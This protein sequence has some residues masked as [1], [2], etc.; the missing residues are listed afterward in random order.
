[1]QR[2]GGIL[3]TVQNTRNTSADDLLKVARQRVDGFVRRGVTTVEIKSGYGLNVEAEYKMLDVARQCNSDKARI[4]TTFLGAHTL[5]ADLKND[6]KKYVNQVITEQLPKCAPIADHIDIF[7]DK[8]AFTLDEA[9]AILSAGQKMG[10]KVKAHAEQIEHSGCAKLVADMKGISADHLE[11][12]DEAG[13]EAM[14][15]AGVVAVMLPGAQFY[16]KDISPPTALL[17][18]YNVKMA[19]GTDL[20]PGSSPVHDILQMATMSTILQGLTVEEAVLG[21][22]KH[23]GLA[24]GMDNVG[25]L[26]PGSVQDL[27]LYRPAPGEPANVESLIQHMGAN[28]C[29]LTVKDGK[30]VWDSYY[31]KIN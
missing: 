27:C 3:S 19:V 24:L 29:M 14:G 12:L 6:R 1:M 13:A 11:R 17:R 28:E 23:A 18:K 16:L 31:P 4:V 9:Q 5:P 25:W 2:G 30:S 22:S 7:C 21:I 8:G 20:N 10:L 15:K 26:G